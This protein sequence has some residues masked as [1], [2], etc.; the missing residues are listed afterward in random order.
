MTLTLIRLSPG[1]ETAPPRSEDAPSSSRCNIARLEASAWLGL[2][3]GL[4][5]ELGLGLGLGLGVRLGLGLGLGSTPNL[6]VN[7]PLQPVA[8][9]LQ[10]LER[11][12]LVRVRVR[13]LG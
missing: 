3:L 4:W 12:T 9:L 13:W 7:A 5:I 6:R 8:P 1:T 10:G 11:P 2:G